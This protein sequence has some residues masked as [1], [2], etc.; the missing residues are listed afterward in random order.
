MIHEN[1]YKPN[2]KVILK[3]NIVS[4][5]NLETNV[6]IIKSIVD[7]TYRIYETE[8]FDEYMRI[9]NYHGLELVFLEESFA[10]IADIYVDS[11]T[12]EMSYLYG[13]E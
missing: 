12:E 4:A 3:D 9:N 5:Y 2:D 8:L 11:D 13:E 10:G 1:L 6:V 7:N